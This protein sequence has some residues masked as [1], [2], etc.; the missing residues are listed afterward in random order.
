MDKA[1]TRKL[2]TCKRSGHDRR[3]CGCAGQEA[4]SPATRALPAQIAQPGARMALSTLEFSGSPFHATFH[5]RS[6]A[7]SAWEVDSRVS[8]RQSRPGSLLSAGIASVA[9]AQDAD[10]AVLLVDQARN[11]GAPARRL[12]EVRPSAP[13]AL[14]A[15][16]AQ[17]GARMALFTLGFL[18]DRATP[19][20][21]PRAP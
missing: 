15:Q 21:M 11:A 20:A 17:P 4:W 2:I 9:V 13:C 5:G 1:W 18:V 3:T 19:R 12:Q 8:T 14:P 10:A 6:P 7:G 16:I